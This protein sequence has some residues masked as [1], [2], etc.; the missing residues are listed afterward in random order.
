MIENVFVQIADTV[1]TELVLFWFQWFGMGE[2]KRLKL[3][4][5]YVI[6]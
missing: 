4:D 1:S 2:Q 6:H 3:G 5:G